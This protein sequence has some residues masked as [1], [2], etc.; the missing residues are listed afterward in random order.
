MENDLN[1][2]LEKFVLSKSNKNE[3]NAEEMNTIL[4][5]ALEKSKYSLS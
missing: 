4:K 2:A 3:L 5:I 1:H